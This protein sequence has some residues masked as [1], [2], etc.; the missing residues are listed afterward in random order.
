MIIVPLGGD[1]VGP[2]SL[3][4]KPETPS[5]QAIHSINPQTAG[6]FDAR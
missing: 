4:A 6:C 1:F 3:D 2:Y 5:R